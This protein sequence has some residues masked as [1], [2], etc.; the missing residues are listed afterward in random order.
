[1]SGRG[2]G[3]RLGKAGSL[4]MVT[5][6]YLTAVGAAWVV[7]EVIGPDRPVPALGLG[8]LASA[9]VIY[10]WS[11]TLDNGSMFDAWWSVLPP[12]AAVW[13]AGAATPAVPDGRIALV[14]VV[15][16][17]WAIRL[18]SNWARDWPGLDHEDWRY[19][20]LYTKGPKALISLG[21]VHVFPAFVVFLGSLSMVPA[22]VWGDRP[23]GVLDG[24]AVVVGLSASVI[25]FVADEQM[26]RFVRVKT[27]GAVMDRGLWRSSRHP[28]YFGEILFW[29]SL[30]LFAV[31]A[32]PAW[33]WTVIGPVAMVVMFLTA[34]IPMLDE[35]SRARRP[36]FDE[37]ANR[38]SGLVPWPTR[39]DQ[40]K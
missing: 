11:L 24:L 36:G 38:T 1:M 9:L 32:D 30:W 12:V 13:L 20:D 15:V 10:A 5:V 17:V 3:P 37:Y 21:G 26:R 22:L 2:L 33:W 25:E 39:R 23:L 35:R 7:A 16:G 8:Y 6:A 4:A 34:S 14:L 18:T 27:P 28:N 31:A 40:Q 29:W 19:L